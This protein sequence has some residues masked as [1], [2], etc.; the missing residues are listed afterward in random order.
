MNDNGQSLGNANGL[1]SEN[2]F[3]SAKDLVNGAPPI[4]E[5]LPLNEEP[6]VTKDLDKQLHERIPADRREMFNLQEDTM[7]AIQNKIDDAVIDTTLFPSPS[8]PSMKWRLQISDSDI[9]S[10]TDSEID[11]KDAAP[12]RQKPF[13]HPIRFMPVGSAYRSNGNTTAS[14]DEWDEPPGML[15]HIEPIMGTGKR[16][17]IELGSLI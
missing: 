14:W 16:V 7:D 2:Y 13:S 9:S 4:P 10:D 8:S 17:T 6:P 12:A 3:A 11:S 1:V 15:S 5:K